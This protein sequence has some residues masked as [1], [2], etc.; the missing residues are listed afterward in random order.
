MVLPRK[1]LPS[2]T[3]KSSPLN[4]VLFDSIRENQDYLDRQQAKSGGVRTTEKFSLKGFLGSLKS[5]IGRAVVLD[6]LTPLSPG[7]VEDINAVIGFQG[8]EQDGKLVFRLLKRK[9]AIIP[10]ESISDA[11]TVPTVTATATAE[12][13]VSTTRHYSS[14]DITEISKLDDIDVKSIQEYKIDADGITAHDFLYYI[15]LDIEPDDFDEDIWKEISIVNLS[16]SA[17]E[18]N[19]TATAEIFAV[20]PFGKPALIINTKTTKLV[21]ESMQASTVLQATH[22]VNITLSASPGT[23]Y[24]KDNWI[25]LVHDAKERQ[26]QIIAVD[27]NTLTVDFSNGVNRLRASANSLDGQSITA[28]NSTVRDLEITGASSEKAYRI[29][30]IIEVGQIGNLEILGIET[31]SITVD[32]QQRDASKTSGLSIASRIVKYSVAQSADLDDVNVSDYFLTKEG[33]GEVVELSVLDVYIKLESADPVTTDQ[34]NLISSIKRLSI[35]EDASNILAIGDRITVGKNEML[36][37]KALNQNNNMNIDVETFDRV[38]GNTT[39]SASVN[40]SPE[41]LTS[42]KIPDLRVEAIYKFISDEIEIDGLNPIAKEGKFFSLVADVLEAPVIETGDT[43]ALWITEMPDYMADLEIQVRIRGQVGASVEDGGLP[44][45]T[46]QDAYKNLILNSRVGPAWVN[47]LPL[48]LRGVAPTAIENVMQLANVAGKLISQIGTKVRHY[49][50]TDR[51]IDSTDNGKFF[52]VKDGISQML[53]IPDATVVTED[54]SPKI[55]HGLISGATRTGLAKSDFLTLASGSLTIEINASSANPLVI[56]INGNNSTYD[57]D[58]DVDAGAANFT[59]ASYQ[60]SVNQPGLSGDRQAGNYPHVFGSN[61]TG[62][63]TVDDMGTQMQAHIGQFACLAHSDG[64]NTSYFYGYI[65]SATRISRVKRNYFF[66][67]DGNPIRA[68]GMSDDNTI[69]LVR[70]AFVLLNGVANSNPEIIYRSPTKSSDAPSNP[71]ANDIWIDQAEGIIKQRNAAN[72]GWVTASKLHVAT[73]GIVGSAVVCIRGHDYEKIFSKEN[74]LEFEITGNT[75][76]SLKNPGAV[77]VEGRRFC[78]ENLVFDLS[79]DLESGISLAA[80]TWYLGA[81]NHEG[82]KV[83]LRD[84]EL[85]DTERGFIDSYSLRKI[86]FR[87]RT[88]ASSQLDAADGN[89]FYIYHRYNPSAEIDMEYNTLIS[90]GNLNENYIPFPNPI[91]NVG[92]YDT[93][94]R[95]KLITFS[96]GVFS[97]RPF[98]SVSP[99]G[100]QTHGASLFGAPTKLQFRL[101]SYSTT[102]GAARDSGIWATIK[103]AGIDKIQTEKWNQL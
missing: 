26:G 54:N 66:D 85:W 1:I 67:V 86:L 18:V 71:M 52:G 15:S 16:G 72:D 13:N 70:T 100:G 37:I 33:L 32:S 25:D 101:F 28:I 5:A 29:G 60:C 61:Q 22:T 38:T 63:I 62:Y 95:R 42:T 12:A 64:T 68:I 36:E 102:D 3:D 6:T 48:P 35:G 65:E 59:G 41:K 24:Q 69:T 77:S 10:V 58:V 91:S 90:T 87:V 7:K 31:D 56:R 49:L 88:N 96:D 57:Q 50:Y 30:D 99:N 83:V 81:I 97:S 27:A 55:R 76:V 4:Q 93:N 11:V 14:R 8:I 19:N 23:G 17:N 98:V 103:R 89:N 47:W 75:Q 44:T 79:T 73:A 51:E 21:E 40:G 39:A 80:N 9:E 34:Q 78:Y 92:E 53:T 74:S 84:D 45:P 46:T 2:Q 82:K 94:T 43:L 20:S